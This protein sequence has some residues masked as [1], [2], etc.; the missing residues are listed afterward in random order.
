[1]KKGRSLS[2]LFHLKREARFEVVTDG[3]RCAKHRHDKQ[4]GN[5]A[6][7]G[8]DRRWRK[9]R[10]QYLKENPLC[11]HCAEQGRVTA[12]NE[13]D[14]IVPHE[15]NAALFWDQD[16][17]QELCKLCHSAKTMRESVQV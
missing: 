5:S 6:E 7:R 14:H 8:Y 4:R 3:G 10:E 12:A 17:W 16:N 2:G 13:V 9:A 15:G 1:M 11:A